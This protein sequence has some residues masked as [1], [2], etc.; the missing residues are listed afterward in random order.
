[1]INRYTN[2]TLKL[3]TK[4][5]Y[6]NNGSNV[7]NVTPKTSFQRVGEQYGPNAHTQIPPL[8]SAIPP[9]YQGGVREKPPV[10][11]VSFTIGGFGSTSKFSPP[12]A[13]ANTMINPTFFAQSASADSSPPNVSR[14]IPAPVTTAEVVKP[15]N[16][17][18]FSPAVEMSA[19]QPCHPHVAGQG[20]HPTIYNRHNFPSVERAVADTIAYR[21]QATP[22]YWKT[23][24]PVGSGLPPRP[25]L[26]PFPSFR[27]P[28]YTPNHSYVRDLVVV[29]PITPR[30][31]DIYYLALAIVP[32]ALYIVAV[33]NPPL[34][35][36]ATLVL[37]PTELVLLSVI[38]ARNKILS[39]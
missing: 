7:T 25:P 24:L 33:T 23:F 35:F 31:I 13:S 17:T 26:A 3:I 30:I 18:T 9:Q 15:E 12:P 37:V 1:M 16:R 5:P 8:P 29:N 28:T 34:F 22:P 20:Q 27:L 6:M 32:I 10:T 39:F 14:P 21:T 38:L 4:E 2:W 36:V 19:H 11:G